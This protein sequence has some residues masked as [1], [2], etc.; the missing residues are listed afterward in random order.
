[1]THLLVLHW[2]QVSQS[3]NV[4]GGDPASGGIDPAVKSGGIEPRVGRGRTKALKGSGGSEGIS[5]S[6]GT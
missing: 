5:G 6:G 3:I 4:S 1:M 2:G